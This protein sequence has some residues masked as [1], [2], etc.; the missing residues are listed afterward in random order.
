MRYTSRALLAVGLLVGFYVLAVAVVVA[1]ATCVVLV[2]RSGLN[3]SS[4]AALALG[5]FTL[6]VCVALVRALFFRQASGTPPGLAVS[7]TDQPALWH[8]VRTLADEVGTSAPDEIRLVG[9]LNAAVSEDS[10][11][12]GLVPGRRRLYLGLPF[13]LGLS[14]LEVRAVLAHELGHYSA[15]HVALGPV[16]YRGK[17]AIGKAMLELGP[18]SVMGKLVGLYGRLYLAVSRSVS[19][20]QELEADVFSARLAGPDASAAALRLLPPLD[21]A[22]RRFSNDYAGLGEDL[23]LRPAPLIEG[24]AAM[25]EDPE[26]LLQLVA[27]ADAPLKETTSLYDTHP[28]L[29]DRIAR[30]EALP[31]QVAPTTAGS[32]LVRPAETF[33]AFEEMA[34]QDTHLEPATWAETVAASGAARARRNRHALGGL[35]GSAAT[36]ESFTTRICHRGPVGLLSGHSTEDE[37]GI[38]AAL[39]GDSISDML[40]QRGSAHFALDWSGPA[41]L[42]STDGTTIDLSRSLQALAE[43]GDGAP[44]RAQVSDLGLDTSEPLPIAEVDVPKRT[45][46]SIL[47]ATGAMWAWPASVLVVT[48][49]GILLAPLSPRERVAW[50]SRAILSR[51]ASRR[52]NQVAVERVLARPLAELRAGDSRFH[53]WDD[54]TAAQVTRGR[55]VSKAEVHLKDGTRRKMSFNELRETAGDPWRAIAHHLGDRWTVR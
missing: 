29:A 33:A 48:P 15:R 35:A 45:G 38:L 20:R 22:W 16:T 28:P 25:L 31:K 21:A 47:G 18:E 50:Y 5:L 30:F 12:L 1:L 13:L 37:R 49:D 54:I 34:Y 52:A 4:A 42:T 26:V 55:T 11:F 53:A 43:S 14:P 44:L 9:S 27:I 2:A 36:L 7:E 8:E 39:L 41:K 17:E 46:P 24:F 51:S 10:R 19:R 3:V 6:G 32:L 40:I 23:G